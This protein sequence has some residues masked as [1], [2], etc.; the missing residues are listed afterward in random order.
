MGS[1]CGQW[2]GCRTDTQTGETWG[3]RLWC[4]SWNCEDCAPKRRKELMAAAAAGQPSTLITLTSPYGCTDT[5]DEAAQQL[6]HAWRMVIQRAKRNGIVDELHYIA[7]FEETKQGWPHLHILARTTFI[8]Q[9]WLS[10]RMRE[11]H[12][13][14]IVDIR[15]VYNAR[16]AS[17]YV[18]KYV[19]KA[20]HRYEGCK[21]YWRSRDYD[22][23][24]KPRL[25]RD[26]S[27]SWGWIS[28]APPELTARLMQKNGW[29]VDWQDAHSYIAWPAAWQPYTRPT[30]DGAG[31]SMQ[32]QRGPDP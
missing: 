17:R 30:G 19:S 1:M 8:S 28:Q 23:S 32:K 20:P 26:D 10:E 21:R 31:W 22:L 25:C 3:G 12:N 14:P 9:K 4:K 16:H 11:Y 29:H 6:V 18:G 2:T 13:A 15:K 5:P 7:V 27:I 24:E